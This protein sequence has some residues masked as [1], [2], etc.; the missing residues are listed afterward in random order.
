VRARS[1]K[2]DFVRLRA[3]A[4]DA[5][6]L[7]L[8]PCAAIEAGASGVEERGPGAAGGPGAGGEA[9]STEL[10]V[11]TETRHEAAVRAALAEAGATVTAREPVEDLD[12]SVAWREGLVPVE[13][14]ARLVV[15]P[16]FLAH[17]PRPGQ[18]AL[19]IEPGQAFGTGGHASTRLA[20]ALLC[21]EPAQRVAGAWVLDVGTGSGVLAL[22]ALR[23]GAGRAVGL[24]LDPLAAPA[25]RENAQ[26]NGLAAGLRV[27]TGPAAALR[28]GRFDLV[29]ANL[30]K[31]ELLPVAA[32]LA[33]AVRRP[34][35]RLVLAGLLAGERAEI[36]AAFAAH[37]LSV[38]AARAETDATDTWLGLTLAP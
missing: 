20:L 25:A 2:A 31:R 23:L 32:Q 19:A 17:A 22:A 28:P 36:A 5:L 21:D 4:R 35:G 29:L 30:L 16:A 9:A 37:G 24:D 15:V 12:W 27:F 3:T 33:A 10:L 26:R 18:A 8:A 38:V 11:Y 1:A 6:A 13:I 7:E 34:G 14:G